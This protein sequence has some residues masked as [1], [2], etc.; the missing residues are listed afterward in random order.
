MSTE[1]TA[2]SH[3][4]GLAESR[5]D[6]GA[7]RRAAGRSAWRRIRQSGILLALVV[8]LFVGWLLSDHFLQV[9]NLLNVSRQAAIV[10]ILGIGMTFV[11]LTAGIDLSVGSIV[12]FSAIAC[13][14]AISEGVP[15]PLGLLVGI[16]AGAV[17]GALN[18]LGITK[19]GLQPFIMTLGMLVIARGVTMTYAEGKPVSLGETGDSLA[20]LGTGDLV[21]LPVPLWILAVLAA[22]AAGRVAL[23]PVRPPRLRG[24]RQPRGGPPVGDQHE[25]RDLLGLRHQ[26]PVCGGDRAD[27]RV[28]PDRR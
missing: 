17:A 12:G 1:I 18:G 24:R 16:A 23:H 13:A 2:A 15:W 10:G 27:H 22:L 8:L 3:A 6:R 9:D 26:R 21:G 11:I 28:P 19:G 14:S 25:P 7:R 20:W 4:T 5:T